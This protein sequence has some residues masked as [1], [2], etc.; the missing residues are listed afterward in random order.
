[1]NGKVLVT[2]ASGLV[3]ASLVRAL[4]AQ[5]REVRALVH[6]DRRALVGLVV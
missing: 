1:M 5:G 3:G 2:G 6:A 4:L